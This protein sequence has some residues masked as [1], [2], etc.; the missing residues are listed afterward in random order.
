MLCIV[1]HF[2]PVIKLLQKGVRVHHRYVIL[3]QKNAKILGEG[4]PPQ[5]GGGHPLPTPHPPRR[6]DR[7]P[8][9]FEILP[10]LLEPAAWFP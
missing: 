9:H 7:N 4:A 8:S 3:M 1:V 2:Q 5:W 6:L 10:T